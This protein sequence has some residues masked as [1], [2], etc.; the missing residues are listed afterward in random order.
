MEDFEPPGVVVLYNVT[1][2]LCKGEPLDLIAEQG[3]ISCA[4]AV[5]AA[6]IEAG[7]RTVPLPVKEGVETAL[8]P[9]SPTEY[10]VFNLGEGLGGRLFEEARVAFVLEALGYCFTGS[11]GLTI[12]L[13]A[14]KARA[15]AILAAAGI[16]TPP[17]YLFRHPDEV[18]TEPLPSPLIV[19]PVAEDASQGIDEGAVVTTAAALRERV[20]YVV[21]R[22]RQAA[23]AEQFI[24]GREFNIALWGNPQPV[25]L[26]LAEVDFS[27]FQ[28]PLECIVSYAA[29]WLEDSFPYQHTPVTC[30]AQVTPS[31]G[32]RIADVACQAYQA[33]GCRDYARVDIRVAEDGTPY[34][35]EVNPNP[36]LSPDA[37]FFRAA[38]AAGYTYTEMVEH[39]LSL[40]LARSSVLSLP[41]ESIYDF[42]SHRRRWRDADRFGIQSGQFQTYR[43]GLRQR[44][45]D[46]VSTAG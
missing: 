40:A 28:D 14:N 1:E 41:K 35:V 44:V 10:A 23:L 31:L 39:I 19:K 29:K 37:G 8:I 46:S 43:G 34:V 30:P 26:P 21:D 17:A 42:I 32:K 5:T 20:A 33:L 4:Q 24:V 38:R 15:K 22:Y 12:A 25:V 36:D 9:Y 11:D 13:G 16:P 18:S 7:H 6:L 27:A 3:V 2:S 45:M